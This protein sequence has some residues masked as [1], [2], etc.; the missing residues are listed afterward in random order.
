[1]GE[2]R[3][4]IHSL[5]TMVRQPINVQYSTISR[6]CGQF[7][8][9]ARVDGLDVIRLPPLLL[10]LADTCYNTGLAKGERALSLPRKR[11]LP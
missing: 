9:T 2:E 4:N 5:Q 10:I 6:L 7:R 3:K 8:H 11:Y 1:M